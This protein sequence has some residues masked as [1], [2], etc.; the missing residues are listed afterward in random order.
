MSMTW[1]CAVLDLPLGGAKGAILFDPRT[2]TV[3]EQERV[4]RGWDAGRVRGHLRRE[5]ARIITGKPTALG[6]SPGRPESTGVA[7]PY[8]IPECS[9]SCIDPTELSP[10]TDTL[11]TIDRSAAADRGYDILPGSSWL[12]QEVDVLIPAAL[13]HQITAENAHEYMVAC[14]SSSRLRTAP[15]RR[16]RVGCSRSVALS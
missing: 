4:S 2:L 10:L 12:E 8:R 1:K 11:G 3:R 13:E 15:Q 16:T 9:R 5:G 6:G 14:E 7:R